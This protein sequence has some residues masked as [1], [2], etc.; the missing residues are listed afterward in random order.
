[1]TTDRASII[2]ALH[3]N[4][5]WQTHVQFNTA[6]TEAERKRELRRLRKERRALE[7]AKM[8]AIQEQVQ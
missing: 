6:F 7:Q 1:M 8:A 3:A 5:K 4:A 2:K